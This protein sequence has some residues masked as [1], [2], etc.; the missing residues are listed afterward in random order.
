[1]GQVL[2][3]TLGPGDVVSL[4]WAGKLGAVSGPGGLGRVL[5]RHQ[6]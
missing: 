3:S 6:G 5:F 4:T 1:M 2:G